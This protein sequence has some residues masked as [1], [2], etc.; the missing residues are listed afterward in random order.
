MKNRTRSTVYSKAMVA[1]LTAI[2]LLSSAI[3]LN[4][5][6]IST[7]PNVAF[8]YNNNADYLA[9]QMIAGDSQLND[10]ASFT[11]FVPGLKG[12]ASNWS[13]DGSNFGTLTYDKDS[14]IEMVRNQTGG[15]LY[16]A[17]MQTYRD[18]DAK[19]KV[20][21]EYKKHNEGEISIWDAGNDTLK[22]KD[23][24]NEK[25][26]WVYK[27]GE[28]SRRGEIEK[29]NMSLQQL[30]I[31]AKSNGRNTEYVDTN[32]DTLQDFNRHSIIL[33]EAS[34]EDETFLESNP[35]RNINSGYHS[36]VY[37]Q[38]QSILDKLSYDFMQVNGRLPRINLIGYS[39]GGVVNVMYATA[40]PK[41]VASI[42]SLGTPYD[43]LNLANLL[44]LPALQ[45]VSMF[46]FDI[47]SMV[48]SSFGYA[49]EDFL[50]LE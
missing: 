17:K 11:V 33:F 13:N 27:D 34:N 30:D 4:W 39:R 7:A 15:L 46:G 28:D 47:N 38:L 26:Q 2:L 22:N 32:V 35:I 50:I 43:G 23:Q 25:G 36:G 24:N 19:Q 6:S 21:V 10:P 16:L 41:Q 5:T 49:A 1:L 48:T 40:R 45:L 20:R 3:L 8:A 9:T 29:F 12:T 44:D 42:Q 14:M 37:F 31:P 18:S